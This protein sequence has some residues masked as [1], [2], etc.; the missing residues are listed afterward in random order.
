MQAV[1]ELF[2]YKSGSHSL[3]QWISCE[4]HCKDQLLALRKKDR[5]ENDTFDQSCKN[6]G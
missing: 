3:L 1:R 4:I 2:D 5:E 6:D